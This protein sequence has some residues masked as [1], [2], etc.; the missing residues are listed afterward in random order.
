MKSGKTV[1]TATILAFL[2]SLLIIA[3]GCAEKVSSDA[4]AADTP[5]LSGPPGS[6]FWTSFANAKTLLGRDPVFCATVDS[7]QKIGTVQDSLAI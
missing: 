7:D 1:F 3:S 6:Q 4:A 5:I 2:I